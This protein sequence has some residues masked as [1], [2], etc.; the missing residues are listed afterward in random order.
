ML[1]ESGDLV[2]C[3]SCRKKIESLEKLGVFKDSELKPL[4]NPKRVVTTTFPIR[5]DNGKI[6]YISGFRVQYNDALGPTKGGVRFHES[7]NPEEVSE[8]AFLMTLKTS[9]L[10]L[11]YGGAK[12]GV[13]I[14]TKKL[15]ESELERVARGYVRTLRKFMG[16]EED[17]PAPDV[18]TNQRVMAWMLDE[19]EVLTGAKS[20][21]VFTGKPLILGGSRGRLTATSMG[22]FHI[23]QSLF[24]GK[25]HSDVKFAIQGF[26]NV[27]MNMAIHLFEAGFKVVAVSDSSGGVYDKSGLPIPELAKLKKS[28]GSLS[29]SGHEQASNKKLLRLPVDVLIPSALGGVIDK[30]IAKKIKASLIVEMANAPVQTDADNILK[31]RDIRVLPDILANAG[32]VLVSYFEWVQ[33][34]QGISWEEGRVEKELKNRMVDAYERVRNRSDEIGCSMREASY[35]EAIQR[36]I[37]AEEFRGHI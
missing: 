12:G 18:N 9:L 22:G 26:G 6:K 5:L 37:K 14:N 25:D 36:I 33:N 17:I 8:L 31:G 30:E 3:G 28:G 10:G 27:G 11:P 34:L 16:P 1:Y 4:K 2:S 24:E 21:A 29:E 20:P 7:T 23:I 32:G 15:S 19:F 13:R 35:I